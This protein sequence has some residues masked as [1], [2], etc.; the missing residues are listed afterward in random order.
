MDSLFPNVCH[1]RCNDS[2]IKTQQ[3][4]SFKDAQTTE[5]SFISFLTQ[6]TWLVS[7]RRGVGNRNSWV[8]RRHLEINAGGKQVVV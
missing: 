7:Q 3:L 2:L 1:H 8:S 5:A 4:V 6:I